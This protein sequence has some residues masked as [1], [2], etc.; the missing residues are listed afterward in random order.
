M[1]NEEALNRL[2]DRCGWIN[3][4]VFEIARKALEERV[5]REKAE[6]KPSLTLNDI[7]KELSSRCTM[8]A[9][10]QTSEPLYPGTHAALKIIKALDEVVVPSLKFHDKYIGSTPLTQALFKALGAYL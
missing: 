8:I 3:R 7:V 2:N 10:H 1:T 4:E 5:E 9:W 6:K